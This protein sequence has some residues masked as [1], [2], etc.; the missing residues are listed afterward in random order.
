M[1][2]KRSV[3]SRQQPGEREIASFAGLISRP[4]VIVGNGPSATL[5]PHKLIPADAVVF[6][7]S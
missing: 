2:P 3:G 6:R 1:P 5:P 7:M 4:L